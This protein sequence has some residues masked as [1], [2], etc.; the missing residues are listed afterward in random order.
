MFFC[1]QI[2]GILKYLVAN[3]LHYVQLLYSSNL[4]GLEAV[5]DFKGLSSQFSICVAQQVAFSQQELVSDESSD[6]VVISLLQ[7]PT[8][9]TVVIF[10]TT[11]QV[12]SFLQ[13]VSRNSLAMVTLKFI[14]TDQWS[15]H[16]LVAGNIKGAAE[17]SIFF[18]HD[19]HGSVKVC[20]LFLFK[21]M[22]FYEQCFIFMAIAAYRYDNVFV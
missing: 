9:N 8:A 2:L 20:A 12:R 7:K 10:A 11:V 17:D 15:E 16:E 22:Y 3:N 5:D 21:C 4:Y 6:D 13:A 19:F 18:V 1:L 14:G